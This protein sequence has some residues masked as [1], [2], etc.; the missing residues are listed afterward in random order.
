MEV[1][2][3]TC[4]CPVPCDAQLFRVAN[5]STSNKQNPDKRPYNSGFAPFTNPFQPTAPA[6]GSPEI[7]RTCPGSGRQLQV[8]FL[9][10]RKPSLNC[11]IAGRENTEISSSPPELFK[12]CSPIKNCNRWFLCGEWGS[13][14]I[15]LSKTPNGQS[16]FSSDLSPPLNGQLSL[17]HKALLLAQ[18]T[19]H[20]LQP[21]TQSFEQESERTPLHK[22]P[23]SVPCVADKRRTGP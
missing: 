4:N 1:A 23:L 13:H 16:S 22:R 9:L 19:T 10:T 17:N 11:Q 21:H 18:V 15:L 12:S 20:S 7:P 3:Y 5:T 2:S 6:G 14:Y 8:P